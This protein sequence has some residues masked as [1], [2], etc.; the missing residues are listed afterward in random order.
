MCD[1]RRWFADDVLDRVQVSVAPL[2]R[3]DRDEAECFRKAEGVPDIQHE[4]PRQSKHRGKVAQGKRWKEARRSE[5]RAAA[6]LLLKRC[7]READ[8]SLTLARKWC[9]QWDASS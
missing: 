4:A 9:L 7:R 6:A 5:T 8:R 3:R 1:S 2:L